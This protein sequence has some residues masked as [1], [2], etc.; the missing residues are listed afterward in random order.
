M[1]SRARLLFVQEFSVVMALWLCGLAAWQYLVG[2][3]WWMI[4]VSLA[5]ALLWCRWSITRDLRRE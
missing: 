1:R 2:Q 4:D 3:A 5:L